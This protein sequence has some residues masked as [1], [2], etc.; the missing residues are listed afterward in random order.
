MDIIASLLIGLFLSLVFLLDLFISKKTKGAFIRALIYAISV[1]LPSIY[2][3]EFVSQVV[4][5]FF[6]G[7]VIGSFS[8]Y[9]GVYKKAIKKVENYDGDDE[10]LE[11][12]NLLMNGYSDFKNNINKRLELI[13]KEQEKYNKTYV[14]VHDDLT[15]RLPK[16]VLSIYSHMYTKDDDFS[17]YATYVMQSFIN[18]FFS[19][20]NARFTLRIYDEEK[21]E[22]I[23]A[24]TTRDIEP[25]N[26]PLS[27]K[28][29][30]SYSL[31]KNKPLIYSEN[32]DYHYD[33]N[34]SIQKKV[35][36]DY[37]T[38]CIEANN[39]TPIIS[40]N[41]DVK[42]EDAVNRMKAFVKTNIFTI[43]CD[44]ITLNYK[45]QKESE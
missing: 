29:M 24:I 14:K 10:N 31:E 40:V 3:G 26:I 18:E 21:N 16:F 34:L 38:Y 11:F 41:L 27:R 2:S 39:S 13:K 36:D 43:V 9:F 1:A 17:K 7:L 25:T 4:Y 44:A 20:S 30:I 32:K 22:M 23:T 33:T 37:V 45:I 6:I 28:N 42:G 12:F 8:V 5:G 19:N 35:F 15:I